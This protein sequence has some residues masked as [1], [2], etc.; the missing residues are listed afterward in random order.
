[1]GRIQYDWTSGASMHDMIYHDKFFGGDKAY[2]VVYLTTNPG[3]LP[4]F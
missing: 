1:M 4:Q 2:N 3:N